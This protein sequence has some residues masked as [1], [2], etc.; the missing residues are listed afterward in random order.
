MASVVMCPLQATIAKLRKL[1]IELVLATDMKQV[2]SIH[3][4]IV[5]RTC[6]D[7]RPMASA[8]SA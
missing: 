2:K 5:V 6:S 7:V 8:L 3:A 1:V 4:C